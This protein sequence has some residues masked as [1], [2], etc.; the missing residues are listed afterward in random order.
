MEDLARL[1][2]ESLIRYGI[3][4]TVNDRW[5]HAETIYGTSN[6]I[7][8]KTENENWVAQQADVA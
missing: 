6:E 4:I 3:Q 8:D 7:E 2:D 5:L 1:V